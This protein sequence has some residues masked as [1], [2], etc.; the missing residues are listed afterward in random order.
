MYVFVEKLASI[1]KKQEL[2]RIELVYLPRII[3]FLQ[4]IIFTYPRFIQKKNS[5]E[6]EYLKH[7]Y[8]YVGL[9]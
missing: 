5:E 6:A 9:K 1:K 7:R 2:L 3:A 8:I 4:E